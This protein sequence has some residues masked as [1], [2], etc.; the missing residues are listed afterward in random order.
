M[1]AVTG[2]C[3]VYYIIGMCKQNFGTGV[4][5]IQHGHNNIYSTS[6]SNM[7]MDFVLYLLF[8]CGVLV[9]AV[10]KGWKR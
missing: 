6:A 3:T 1:N 2:F 10:S 8:S 5:I 4:W 7:S 9:N